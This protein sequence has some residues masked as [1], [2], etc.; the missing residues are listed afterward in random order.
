VRGSDCGLC[1]MHMHGEP[2]TMQVGEP[3]YVDVVS[4][5][6][7]FLARRCAELEAAGVAKARI[8]VD[9]GF[10]FG[11]SVVE[12]NYALLAHLPE[13][14]PAVTPGVAPYPILAGMSRKSMLGALVNRPAPE[15]V[16]ASVAAAVCAAQRGAAIIRVH[17]VAQTV[18]ALKVWGAMRD[19]M[20]GGPA[21][22]R[23]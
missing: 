4:E 23:R 18:D 3:D 8:S 22:A 19:A 11:K 6:R 15:R 21:P 16:A 9:P 2:Q 20:A 12:H 5:V 10:G 14:A 17:D 7:D 13:T 1:V